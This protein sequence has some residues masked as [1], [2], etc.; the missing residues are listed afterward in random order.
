VTDYSRNK[1]CGLLTASELD[2]FKRGARVEQTLA[3]N[4]CW[5]EGFEELPCG[6]VLHNVTTEQIDKFDRWLSQVEKRFANQGA[7]AVRIYFASDIKEYKALLKSYGY[8]LSREKGLAMEIDKYE[9]ALIASRT[10][11]DLRWV[12]IDTQARLRDRQNL[13]LSADK[14]PDG[15]NMNGFRFA[16]FEQLKMES[17]YMTSFLLYHSQVA[18]GT[19]S[20]SVHNEFARL[21]N[22]FVHPEFRRQGLARRMTLLIL[23]EA[24]A[25][26]ALYFGAYALE[27]S[28]GHDVYTYCGMKDLIFQTECL[29][30][31]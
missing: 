11:P 15:H 21:K 13:Y 17:G 12:E 24:R 7:C 20:L 27:G 26:R 23:E 25:K 9:K 5:I 4:L 28:Q 18:V 10:Y 22:L 2:Y 6:C 8:H 31:L 14:G 16:D 19:V 1:I 29:K 3:G 30:Y